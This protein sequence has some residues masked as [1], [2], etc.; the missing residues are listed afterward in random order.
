MVYNSNP[1]AIAP[2]QNLVLRGLRRPDLFTVVLE[3]FQTDTADYAD[4]LLP[5][6]DFSRTHRPL[7]RLRPLP[8]AIGAAGAVRAPG[9]TQSNVE[10]FRALA[11]R[12][13]FE[14]PCF[15]GFRGRHDPRA[16]RFGAIRF[17]RESRS[18]DSERNTP[19]D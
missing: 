11:V 2:N 7:S 5:V 4:I 19:Y 12:M 6:D 17:W 14:E 1:A 8:S 15:P 10:I 9:E 13:G 18:S 3:Q 16:A